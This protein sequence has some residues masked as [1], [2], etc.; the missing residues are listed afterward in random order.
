MCD[1]C[2]AA[3][4]QA[5]LRKRAA[6]T[7]AQRVQ[8]L[9]KK[10]RLQQTLRETWEAIATHVSA[11][12][13]QQQGKQ[14]QGKQQQGKQQQGKQQQGKQQQGK[15]QQGKQQQQQQQQQQEEEEQEEQAR[16]RQTELQAKGDDADAA[17]QE[18]GNSENTIAANARW[19]TYRCPACN[20][21]VQSTVV[22]G[23]VHSRGHCGRQFRVAAGVVCRS[24]LHACPTCN[25]TVETTKPDGRIQKQHKDSTGRLCKTS[26][27]KS[28]GPVSDAWTC[29]S[30]FRDNKH[31]GPEEWHWKTEAAPSK[32]A[33]MP[34][35]A[36]WTDKK[37]APKCSSHAFKVLHNKVLASGCETAK[38]HG[39]EGRNAPAGN[40]STTNS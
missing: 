31:H 20:A 3:A 13:Q 36:F 27:W 38:H 35:V 11:R 10:L 14:Q 29:G 1:A 21:E 26:Q 5:T 17:G 34:N 22:N 16:E 23:K 2:H 8:P 39:P 25:T 32:H 7:T 18:K 30:R 19:R 24:Y 33:P 12:Q 6:Q 4:V 9:R 15:Q 37:P 40:G 28:A